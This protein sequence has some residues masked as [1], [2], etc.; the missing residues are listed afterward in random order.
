M[1]SLS[2]ARKASFVPRLQALDDRIVP[3]VVSFSTTDHCLTITGDGNSETVRIFDNGTGAS[4]N[5]T[6]R[7]GGGADMQIP[8]YISQ[9]NADMNGGA[10]TVYY[11]QEGNLQAHRYLNI[12]L[13]SGSDKFETVQMRDIKASTQLA[14]HVEG[15]SGDDT[16]NFLKST[17]LNVDMDIES[18]ATLDA[19]LAGG[20]D[21]DTINF[22]YRGEL[23]GRIRLNILGEGGAD[24]LRADI[25]LDAGST[26]VVADRAFPADP[27]RPM[28]W[29]VVDVPVTMSGGDGNDDM[30]FL[31]HNF[32]TAATQARMD[33]GAGVDQGIRTAN[34]EASSV[35]TGIVP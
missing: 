19:W 9:V 32:G 25:T 14:L 15:G 21:Q 12:Q 18:G 22:D 13:G 30:T 33:G 1:R 23:D 16:L 7:V 31:I 5:I 8:A 26:G 11:F 28:V 29:M 34:V 35:Y 17:F 20:D 6:V 2:P 24:T 10:D 27:Y 3:T 4:G